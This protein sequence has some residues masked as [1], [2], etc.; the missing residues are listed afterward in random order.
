MNPLNISHS[1]RIVA[2]PEV[3]QFSSYFPESGYYIRNR[4]RWSYLHLTLRV[5]LTYSAVGM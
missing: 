5:L 2:H 1:E 3:T 4:I